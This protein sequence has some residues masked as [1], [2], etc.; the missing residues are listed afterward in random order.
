MA[1]AYALANHLK[2]L[3]TLAGRDVQRIEVGRLGRPG[4]GTIELDRLADALCYQFSGRVVEVHRNLGVTRCLHVDIQRSLLAVIVLLDDDILDMYLRTG[5]QVHFAGNT[6]QAPEVLVLQVRAVTPAHH[7]HGDKVL[8][9]LHIFRDVKLSGNLRVLAIAHILAVH[10]H[11]QVARGRTHVEQHLLA[12][13]T[14]GQRECT[15]VRARIVLRLADVWRIGFEGRTPG[16]AEVLVDGVAVSVQLK[17]SWYWEVL[18]LRVVIVQ[19]P[20][21]LGGVLMIL[22]KTEAPHTL[23]RQVALRGLFLP[24]PCRLL[25]F[26]GEEVGPSALTILLIYGWIMPCCSHCQHY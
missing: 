5:I 3:V 1:E 22:D 19:R 8:P 9:F 26:A 15:A 17:Q 18:P 25:V 12:L 24:H 20:E 7:L 11:L 16:I 13:P 23:H 21:S 14:V 4:L 10:P 2:H 6:R